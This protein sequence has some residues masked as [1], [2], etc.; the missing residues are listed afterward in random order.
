MEVVFK[1]NKGIL[2]V[3]SVRLLLC[4]YLCYLWAKIS[5]SFRGDTGC[6]GGRRVFGKSEEQ[7]H[8]R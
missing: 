2:D 4:F 7:V 6:G 3:F 5:S 1:T 8:E